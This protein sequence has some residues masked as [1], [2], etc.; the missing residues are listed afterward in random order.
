MSRGWFGCVFVVNF[1]RYL[2]KKPSSV[3]LFSPMY[4]FLNKV[5]MMQKVRLVEIHVTL[6]VT[7]TVRLGPEILFALEIKG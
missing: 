4:M 3:R 6:S 2:W 7:A 5:Q 1:D